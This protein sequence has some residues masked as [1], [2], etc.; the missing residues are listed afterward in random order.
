MANRYWVGG[1]ENWNT[2][3]GSKWSTTSGGAGGEAVPTSSDDV[4]FDASSGAV[5]VT[6]SANSVCKTLNFT[7]FTG[8]FAKSSNI[9][10]SGNLTLGSGMTLS[11][12]GYFNFN[13]TATIIS[14]GISFGGIYLNINISSSGTITL[15]DDFISTATNSINMAS[16]GITFNANNNNITIN[17]FRFSGASNGTVNMGSGLWTL[18]G[19]GTV[20][21]DISDGTINGDT[22]T[23]KITN[24]T[25]NDI[26]F[27]SN[28]K[29]FNNIWF[30]RGTS[31][32]I[33]TIKG[34]NTFTEFKD[35]GTV[36]HTIKFTDATDQTI[37]SLDINGS[38]G[39]LITLTGT[40]TG[41]WAISDTTGTNTVNYCN[42]SYSTATGGATFNATNSIDGGNNSGWNITGAAPANVKT[43]QGVAKA[44]VKTL[45]GVA[46]ASV[47]SSQGVV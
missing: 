4:Y 23:I 20:W 33:I 41:G 45:Q 15:G 34:S 3:A 10:I 32:G 46:I 36:A 27:F 35:T 12:S 6:V 43:F 7:G 16:S 24:T 1:T 31:T 2:T 11:G 13:A 37:T 18:T 44:S 29:T 5:T 38:S 22:S 19:Y 28:G 47:K 26:T 39:K 9:T 25:N 42:I 14:N 21:E 30:N 40:S 8:T 17:N